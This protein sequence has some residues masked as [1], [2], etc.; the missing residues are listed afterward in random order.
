M[1]NN[2]EILIYVVLEEVFQEAEAI[3]EK[4]EK[5]AAQI[6]KEAQMRLA[7]LQQKAK[8]DSR[9]SDIV[10]TKTK[11]ISQS[12]LQ[13][14]MEVI[15]QK[16]AMVGELLERLQ[17]EFFDLPRQPDYPNILK[18]LILEG[19][20]ALKKEGD[21]FTCQLNEQD[22]SFISPA[23]LDEAARKTGKRITLDER[24]MESKGGAVIWRADGQVFYNNSLEAIFQR[25]HDELRCL[26]GERL[27]ASV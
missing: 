1:T 25:W 18:G 15:H 17:E 21:E 7:E 14:R 23:L 4:A 20:E 8:R 6:K 11:I 24:R 16:E 5:E 10:F 13:A 2:L 27:F 9:R 22:R 12:A 26:A 3:V 19:L